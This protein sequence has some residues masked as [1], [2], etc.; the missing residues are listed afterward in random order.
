MPFII[1]Y[2]VLTGKPVPIKGRSLILNW[3]TRFQQMKT[4]S[5]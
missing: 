3:K 4:T 2:I 1:I 5:L